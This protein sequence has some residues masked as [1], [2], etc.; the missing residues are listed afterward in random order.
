MTNEMRLLLG[1]CKALD[2]NVDKQYKVYI[3]GDYLRIQDSPE[4]SPADKSYQ[5]KNAVHYN[6]TKRMNDESRLQRKN[7]AMVSLAS[8]LQAGA[9]TQADYFNQMTE[10]NGK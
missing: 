4:Q 1:M 2:L 6:V 8:E 5:V 7:N 3:N 9:I 10:L